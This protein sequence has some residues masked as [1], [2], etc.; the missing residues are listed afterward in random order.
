MGADA[1]RADLKV[2]ATA[3]GVDSVIAVAQ[4]LR[5]ARQDRSVTPVAQGLS[6]AKRRDN[7]DLKVCATAGDAT[8]NAGLKACATAMGV[9][10]VIAVAQGLSPARV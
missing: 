6:P 3:G 4:A 7:A 8:C 9:D 5:P 2:C 10:S 1:C